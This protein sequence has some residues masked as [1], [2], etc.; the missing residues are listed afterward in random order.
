MEFIN[1]VKNMFHVKHILEKKLKVLSMYLLRGKIKE[2]AMVAI[3]GFKMPESCYR[4]VFTTSNVHDYYGDRCSILQEYIS[5]G[6]SRDC[7]CPLVEV[8]PCLCMEE[9]HG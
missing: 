1:V 6:K 8:K 9:N 2:D 4:C 7:N 3:K 5:Y